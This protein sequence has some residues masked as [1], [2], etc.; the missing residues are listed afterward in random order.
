[1]LLK[2]HRRQVSITYPI[3][4]AVILSKYIIT[5]YRKALGEDVGDAEKDIYQIVRLHEQP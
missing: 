2:L 3:K 5:D 1:M 4:L